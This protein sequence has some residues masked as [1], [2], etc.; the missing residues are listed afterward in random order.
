MVRVAFLDRDG[1]INVDRGYVHRWDQWEFLD[2]AVPAIGMLRD[3]G[4]LIAVVSNQSGIG[5]GLFT[6]SDVVQLHAAMQS[7]LEQQGITSD[8]SAICPHAPNDGCPCRKPLGGLAVEVEHGLSSPIDYD[9]SWIIGDK[10]TDVEFGKRIG[11][12]CGL[13]RSRYWNEDSLPVVP[14]LIGQSLYEIARVI[15]SGGSSGRHTGND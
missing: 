12:Q 1:T 10:S 8:A 2:G 13:I 15:I 14:D 9:Q 7:Q 6:Q 4:Y 11:A 5:R 3:A